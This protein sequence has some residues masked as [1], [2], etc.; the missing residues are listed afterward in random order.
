MS[1]MYEL[2]EKI[3]EDYRVMNRT[4][5]I[6]DQGSL[7]HGANLFGQFCVACHGIEGKGDGPAAS[8]M[9]SRP[10]NFL[11]LEH[12]AIYGAGEKYWII[13][14][15]SGSTGMPGFGGELS[16]K[17]RWDLVNYIYHLQGKQK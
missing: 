8:A 6:P 2:K 3:P 12:S 4:P 15:G 10:A 1:Q 14:N 11:D 5:V 17:D 13:G 16:P 7:D 9:T